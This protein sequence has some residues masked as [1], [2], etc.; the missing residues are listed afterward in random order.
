MFRCS[1]W[2]PPAIFSKICYL[3][4]VLGVLVHNSLIQCL[5]NMN[6]ISGFKGHSQYLFVFVKQY[7]GCQ[8]G[9]VCYS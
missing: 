3:G 1:I 7:C 2:K 9:L 4:F 5:L 6:T 8:Y